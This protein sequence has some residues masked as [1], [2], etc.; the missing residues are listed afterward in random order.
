MSISGEDTQASQADREGGELRENG[1][2]LAT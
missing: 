1:S 2:E